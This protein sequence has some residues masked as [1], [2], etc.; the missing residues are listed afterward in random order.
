[1]QLLRQSALLALQ[2]IKSNPLHT[3]LSTLGIIIGVASLVAIL[4]LGDG[5]EETAKDRIEART[6]LESISVSSI[7]YKTV[8][9]IRVPISDPVFIDVDMALNIQETLS[10]ESLVNLTA[11]RTTLLK[12]DTAE[13]P[14][15]F[16]GSLQD[17]TQFSDYEIAYGKAFTMEDVKTKNP[18]A[19]VTYKLAQQLDSTISNVVGRVLEVEDK[20]LTI[21][22]VFGKL[23]EDA[24]RIIFPVTMYWSVDGSDFFPQ[25]E[26]KM[27][28]VAEVQDAEQELK[29]WLDANIQKGKEAFQITTSKQ[30]L[31]ELGKGILLFKVIMGAITGISVLVGGIGIM[32]VL[33][34]SVTERTKEIGIRKAAGAKKKDIVFQFLSES[35]TI[36]FVGCIAGCVLGIV[37]VL[38][39]IPLV[40]HLAD[41]AEFQ[42]AFSAGSVLTVMV[43]GALVG[44]VF[45]TYPAWR[46]SQ[47]T[48]VDAIRH[49]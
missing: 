32:N 41:G 9:N 42:I 4:A 15:V 1:M 5:L 2:N 10:Y 13:V 33:L 28:D 24:P 19:I 17:G 27:E 43:I 46:A 14:A 8:N 31:E 37:G 34:I 26:I 35:V 48:P 36:S 44:V 11:A 49:E 23:D 21:I 38:I 12:L 3:L 25:L 45:G 20:S 29:T 39:F 40:N 47:L 30:W 6:G 16:I 7:R 22:G 18:V